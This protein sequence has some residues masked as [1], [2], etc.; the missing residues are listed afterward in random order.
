MLCSRKRFSR[1]KKLYTTVIGS[2]T[3]SP[4]G[5]FFAHNVRTESPGIITS[6]TNLDHAHIG[7]Y[8]APLESFGGP[9]QKRGVTVKAV[10]ELSYPARH[11][12][13]CPVQAGSGDDV[14]EFG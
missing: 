1:K 6:F 2:D 8:G 7:T 3:C 14:F 12:M 5:P 11:P 13:W 9:V 4:L 10:R